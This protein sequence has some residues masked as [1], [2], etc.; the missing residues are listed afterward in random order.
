MHKKFG[1]IAIPLNS[2]EYPKHLKSIANPPATLYARG[3]LDLL[4]EAPGIAI[5]GTRNA[6][7]NGLEITK[8]VA[9]YAVSKGAIVVSG[10]ALGI[11]AAAHQGCLNAGGRTIA[12]LASG[13]HIATPR[14]NAGLG[15][16]ILESDG[17]WV[18]EHPEGTPPA[19][20]YFVP[21]NRIQV[22]LSACSVII[23]S[24]VKSGTTTHAKFCVQEK[25]PLFAVVPQPRNP[26]GLNSAGPEM[27]V[28][29]MGAI[30]LKTRNDYTLLNQA[31]HAS[32]NLN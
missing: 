23:E 22:G 20:Q 27:M 11:D 5:V 4:Y 2:S 14:Q 32:H 31:L 7:A 21:R 6:T 1:V 26:F 10:L 12:V 29:D 19:R 28:R 9:A 8:R 17:L 24:D 15:D 13:L 16:A 30:P 25:H 18:S 3:N